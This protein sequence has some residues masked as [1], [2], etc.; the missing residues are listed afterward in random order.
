MTYPCTTY[1]FYVV[2]SI[3][4]NVE[5]RINIFKTKN[6]NEYEKEFEE[7]K[8]ELEKRLQQSEK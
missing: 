3:K 8:N 2:R 5:V 4:I 7:S 1:A 6:M